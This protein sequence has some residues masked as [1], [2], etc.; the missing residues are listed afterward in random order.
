MAVVVGL[1]N[2][3]IN[4]LANTYTAFRKRHGEPNAA[5]LRSGAAIWVFAL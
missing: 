5:T 4:D 2:N 1:R 3:H